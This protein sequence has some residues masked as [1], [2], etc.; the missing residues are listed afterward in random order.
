MAS[1]RLPRP[2]VPDADACPPDDG[3]FVA[4]LWRSVDGAVVGRVHVVSGRF[5]EPA[6]LVVG[7]VTEVAEALERWLAG[8]YPATAETVEDTS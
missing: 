6:M 3:V 7:G 8:F 5:D 1:R 4:S 2:G